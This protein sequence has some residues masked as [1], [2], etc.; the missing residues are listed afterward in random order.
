MLGYQ[1]NRAGFLQG[2]CRK[3]P[4]RKFHLQIIIVHPTTPLAL[5]TGEPRQLTTEVPKV[6]SENLWQEID[7]PLELRMT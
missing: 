7:C 2:P 6:F 3:M 1:S 5:G 4:R